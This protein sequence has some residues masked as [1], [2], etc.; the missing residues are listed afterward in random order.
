MWKKEGQ[1]I[2]AHSK[3][4]N[5]GGQSLIEVLVA[6]VVVMIMVVALIVVILGSLKNSQFAQKQVQATKYAQ[7]AIDKVRA[8]RDREGLISFHDPS[9]LTCALTCTSPPICNFSVFWSCPLT[10]P[11]SPC[12]IL[13]AGETEGCYFL[14]TDEDSALSE[15]NAVDQISDQIPAEDMKREIYMKD[16]GSVGEKQVI[17]KVTWTDSAGE[18]E[19][20]LQTILT[21]H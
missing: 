14:L 12:T 13:K 9:A 15:P 8:I 19:S 5:Q 2:S 20:N 18:H 16:F 6:L 7:E 10:P 11:D 21:Q 1:F 17:V 4:K 3:M